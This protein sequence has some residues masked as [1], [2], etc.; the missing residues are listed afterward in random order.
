MPLTASSGQR[1]GLVGENG[2][3]ESTLPCLL[4]GAEQPDSGSV[5]RP[6][7]V[8]FLHQELPFPGESDVAATHDRWLRRHWP[9]REVRLAG[10]VRSPKKPEPSSPR[11]PTCAGPTPAPTMRRRRL[12]FVIASFNQMLLPAQG[13]RVSDP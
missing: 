6:D 9:G 1:L 5:T 4:A 8:G 3:G 11:Q 7:D 2:V 13:A 12:E 10:G